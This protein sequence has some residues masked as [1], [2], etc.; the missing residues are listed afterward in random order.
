MSTASATST[1]SNSSQDIENIAVD[2]WKVFATER[3]QALLSRITGIIQ[4]HEKG[5]RKRTPKRDAYEAYLK[6][7]HM[8]TA[9][10][11]YLHIL[12][13]HAGV[14]GG[15]HVSRSKRVLARK[16]QKHTSVPGFV[17][18]QLLRLLDTFASTDL[19]RQ[20]IPAVETRGRMHNPFAKSRKYGDSTVIYPTGR[21]LGLMYDLDVNALE[22]VSRN[23]QGEEIV[24]LKSHQVDADDWSESS[25]VDYPDNAV[26]DKYRATLRQIQKKIDAAMTI[27]I[28][29]NK[30]SIKTGMLIDSRMTRLRRVFTR[31]RWDSCGRY[32][33]GWWMPLGKEE[34]LERIVLDGHRVAELDFSAMM[35]RLAY[36]LVRVQPKVGDLYA[37]P[38]FT[39]SRDCMKVLMLALLFDRPGENRKRLPKGARTGLHREEK[40][41]TVEIIQALKD[42]H[43]PLGR[44]F[45]SGAGHDLLFRE[46]Q[47]M[48]EILLRINALGIVGLPI[49]DAILVPMNR[50]EEARGV[51]EEV[52]SSLVGVQGVVKVTLPPMIEAA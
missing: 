17:N 41:P 22:D 26:A 50:V 40:R 5:Q 27:V 52:F 25:E 23:A 31:N 9:N 13:Q 28:H 24:L 10:L 20:V 43:K 38:G 8:L 51:M 36:G 15:L 35:V 3:G 6:L 37:I 47:V 48:T 7:V 18:E 21:F 30:P 11:A 12:Q 14:K 45:G 46:S 16:R 34:R 19:I 1:E 4:D 2:Y 29:E 33:G 44:L 32:Y 42:Y 49:H 39:K